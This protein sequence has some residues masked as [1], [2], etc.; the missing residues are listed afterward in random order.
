MVRHITRLACSSAVEVASLLRKK[1]GGTKKSGGKWVSSPAISKQQSRVVS[2]QR[3][4]TGEVSIE[5]RGSTID[6]CA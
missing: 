6:A 5:K 2:L 3:T 1:R 4:I